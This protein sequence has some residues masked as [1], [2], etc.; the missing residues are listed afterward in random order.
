MVLHQVWG[1]SDYKNLLPG[2][3]MHGLPFTKGL[4]A[5]R[6]LMLEGKHPVSREYL[7]RPTPRYPLAL[8]SYTLTAMSA[9]DAS[10]QQEYTE[11]CWNA[12]NEGENN[13][14]EVLYAQMCM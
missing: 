13:E 8:A 4:L 2:G 1:K 5:A 6:Q 12:I 9:Y 7:G 11:D 3:V 14:E 10:M